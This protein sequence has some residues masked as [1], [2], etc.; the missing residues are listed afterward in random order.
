MRA[1]SPIGVAHTL[2]VKKLCRAAQQVADSRLGHQIL[3]PARIWLDFATQSTDKHMQIMILGLV[4][5]TPD[6]LE[7]GAVSDDF[8][9]VGGQI[10]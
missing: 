1:A 9:G 10:F 7:Q 4:L 3:R 6:R 5:W 2:G 8:A